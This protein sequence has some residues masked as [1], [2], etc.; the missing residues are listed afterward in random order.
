MSAI[1]THA[2]SSD[3]NVKTPDG[4]RVVSKHVDGRLLLIASSLWAEKFH[5][6]ELH[7][8]LNLKAGY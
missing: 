4:R 6:L 2:K 3:V 1:F 7:K 5:R 8:G